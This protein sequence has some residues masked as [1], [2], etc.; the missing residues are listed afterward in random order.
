M[1]KIILAVGLGLI[2]LGGLVYFNIN[3][4]V[5]KETIYSGVSVEGIDVSDKSKEEAVELLK[6]EKEPTLNKHAM[7]LKGNDKEYTITLNDIGYKYDYERAVNQAHELAREGTTF[8]RYKE[9]T[10]LK[11]N[12]KDIKFDK[13]YDKTKVKAQIEKI[14]EEINTEAKDAEFV[15]NDGDIKVNDGIVGHKVEEA[16]LLAE[17][18]N[19]IDKLEDIDIPIETIDP[20]HDKEYYSKINGV[21]GESTTSFN[22]SGPGRVNNI[23]LST[24][25]F[26]G[27]L[28]HPGEEISY[29]SSLGPITTK[30][31]YQ[32]APVIIA[33]DLTPGV[34]GGICQTSTTLYNA[35][36]RA[37][38]T[39]TERS[40]HSIPSAYMDK[41]LDA[42][43]AGD[44]LDLKFKNE[45][46]YPVYID[47]KVVDRKVTFKIYGDKA[48]KD[49]VIEM[50]PKLTQ[51]IPHRVKEVVKND[52]KP[53]SRKLAQQGRDG[54][55]VVT[56]KHKVKDGK[57]IETKQVN[58]D[59]YRERDTIYNV[60]PKPQPKPTPKPQAKPEEPKEPEE[61]E[62]PE[63]EEEEEAPAA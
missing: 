27:K 26:D 23:K 28:I 29:N 57:V 14:A 16:K 18:E 35:L 3:T 37:E 41:G 21:I 49:Y 62:Q 40:H 17:I 2:L 44:Y 1:K 53:G 22:T 55:K 25:A 4:T 24:R 45:F 33:G 6:A 13:D 63:D 15:F 56:Y 32:D 34:G 51:V 48:N 11:R 47:A 38:L 12:N 31:G 43:V 9:I 20:Q 5:N 19:N 60:G 42:V 61:P 46:D 39:V 36:L 54:Y 7:I 30:T 58:S 10:A 59:Y 8:E 50:Q 52:M